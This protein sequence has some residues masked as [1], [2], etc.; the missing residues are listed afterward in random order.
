MLNVYDSSKQRHLAPQPQL[1]KFTERRLALP[2]IARWDNKLAARGQR[3]SVITADTA[4][5]IV[6][7]KCCCSVADFFF[8]T[9]D[10]CFVNDNLDSVFMICIFHIFVVTAPAHDCSIPFVKPLTA[11]SIPRIPVVRSESGY[12]RENANYDCG[13]VP[14]RSKVGTAAECWPIKQFDSRGSCSSFSH[15]TL[16]PVE[17]ENHR[18]RKDW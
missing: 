2:S 4:I 6:S 8:T 18:K 1:A 12:R 10:S 16:Q 14:E 11:S 7:P 17:E 9:L 3:E 15:S 13:R 5:G